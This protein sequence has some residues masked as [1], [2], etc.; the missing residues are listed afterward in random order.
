MF[1]EDKWAQNGVLRVLFPG[2]FN[3]SSS[4][5]ADLNEE[6]VWYGNLWQ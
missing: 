1:W 2:M 6:E 4:K 3:I 5:M